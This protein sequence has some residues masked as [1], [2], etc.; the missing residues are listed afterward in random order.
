MIIHTCF[1]VC[2]GERASSN[3]RA[4]PGRFPA[5]ESPNCF[6]RY[7]CGIPWHVVVAACRATQNDA[8]MNESSL[9]ERYAPHF[10]CFGCGPANPNGL[11]LRSFTAVDGVGV[12]ADW[13]PEKHHQAFGG[14]L[15]G[16]IIGALLDC[17]S[18]WAAAMD[19]MS[20]TGASKP[21]VL[22][23]AEYTIK[24]LRPT[25]TD[26]PVHLEAC[27]AET[28]GDRATV[29]GSLVANGKTCA[30]SVAVFVAVKPGHPAY[31]AW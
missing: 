8:R 31:H 27:V 1:L 21:P 18:Y 12:V 9:Q 17:H 2:S 6:A 26:G 24:M 25:P 10:A 22:V 4:G 28:T 29:Q 23:T 13:T 16:G 20:R 3:V 11:H 5:K 14:V 7:E 30:T 19:L 15:N